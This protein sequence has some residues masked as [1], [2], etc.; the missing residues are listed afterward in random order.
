MLGVPFAAR[1][2]RPARPFA[3]AARRRNLDHAR[4]SRPE[5]GHARAGHCR[6][7]RVYGRAGREDSRARHRAQRHSYSCAHARVP[8][9]TRRRRGDHRVSTNVAAQ[10][11]APIAEKSFSVYECLRVIFLTPR[12]APRPPGSLAV[13]AMMRN[14]RGSGAS[15][16]AHGKTKRERYAL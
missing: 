4:A 5:L 9:E 2:K 15:Q 6:I 3:V 14:N 13:Q 16:A 7:S 11:V 10:P 8:P 12:G 1:R